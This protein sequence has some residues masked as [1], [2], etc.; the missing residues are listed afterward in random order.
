MKGA[1]LRGGMKIIKALTYKK[2]MKCKCKTIIK[3]NYNNSTR[4]ESTRER[5][6]RICVSDQDIV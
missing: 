6:R 1:P 2:K 3:F 5:G 4:E